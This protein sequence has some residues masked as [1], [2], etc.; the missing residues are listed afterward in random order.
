ML[1]PRHVFEEGLVPAGHCPNGAGT[2]Q[3][4]GSGVVWGEEEGEG[5]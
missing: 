1:S 5:E 2:S 3:G 4:V